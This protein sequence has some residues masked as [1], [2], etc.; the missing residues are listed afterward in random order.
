MAHEGQKVAGEYWML[1]LSADTVGTSVLST[2]ITAPG[3]GYT[4]AP[5]V[6]L[7]APPA[8]GVQATATATVVAGAVT[9]ITIT[10]PG[11]GYLVAPTVT[12][13]PTS[14]GTGAT[15]TTTL[16]INYLALICEKT[17]ELKLDRAEIDASS[18]CGQDKAPGLKNQS[19]TSE[20]L[21]IQGANVGTK[22]AS[23]AQIFAWYLNPPT[24]AVAWKLGPIVPKSG[25]IVMS[26]QCWVKGASIK[27]TNQDRITTSLDLVLYAEDTALTATP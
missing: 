12:L 15:A 14:G 22:E 3:T 8:G 17:T 27:A 9:G 6:A 4:T 2:T 18:K 16:G 10:N 11:S 1:Q 23:F 20:F 24:P 21:L 19:M 25:D 26:G 13:T 5:T 7:T